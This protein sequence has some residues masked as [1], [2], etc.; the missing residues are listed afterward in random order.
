MPDDLMASLLTWALLSGT[1]FL[2]SDVIGGPVVF[3]RRMRP[4]KTLVSARASTLVGR[5]VAGSPEIPSPVL[6]EPSCV[7]WQHPSAHG[8]ARLRPF[9]VETVSHGIVWL[10]AA[11][12]PEFR[13]SIR[14]VELTHRGVAWWEEQMLRAAEDLEDAAF[15]AE[16]D[17]RAG[18]SSSNDDRIESEAA[19]TAIMSG[20][21]CAVARRRVQTLRIGDD[22]VVR[23]GFEPVDSTPTNYRGMPDAAVRH[24]RLVDPSTWGEYASIHIGGVPGAKREFSDSITRA[25]L[26]FFIGALCGWVLGF[27]TEAMG[28]HIARL[29]P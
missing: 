20:R 27:A 23:G 28:F 16:A 15:G 14:S 6:G 29:L 3:R 7:A 5:V 9:A 17:A 18:R 13:G 25:A 10:T 26:L 19:L 1:L 22:V 11:S 21:E 24:Y 12:L 4:T 2:V 8:S